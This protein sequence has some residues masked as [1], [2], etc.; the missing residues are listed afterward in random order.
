MTT[1]ATLPQNIEINGVVHVQHWRSR[2]LVIVQN[3]S[4]LFTH[5]PDE[6]A[7]VTDVSTMF[8]LFSVDQHNSG[9]S[10][11]QKLGTY[12]GLQSAMNAAQK[13]QLP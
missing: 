10:L 9:E 3:Y 11:G 6:L 7:K 1:Y 5:N 13:L 4:R 2:D 8:H 12:S